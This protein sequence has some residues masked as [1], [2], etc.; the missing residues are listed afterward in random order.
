[1]PAKILASHLWE[2]NAGIIDVLAFDFIMRSGWF[3]E[4][5]AKDYP[6][7]QLK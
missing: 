1:L 3:V 7:F 4:A 2:R 5:K 6:K